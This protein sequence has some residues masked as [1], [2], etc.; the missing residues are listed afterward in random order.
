MAETVLQQP[1]S[2]GI[3]SV[4]FSYS[5]NLL[6]ATAWDSSVRLYDAE[7]NVLR[8]QFDGGAAVLDGCFADDNTGFAGGL[9]RAL[10]M[11]VSTVDIFKS[12]PL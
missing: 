6:L 3:S 11:W 8:G 4:K 12:P 1:P 5:S 10:T 7:K 9:D 2:D